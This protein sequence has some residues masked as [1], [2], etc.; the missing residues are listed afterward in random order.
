MYW[1]ASG[2]PPPKKNRLALN[3]V[4]SCSFFLFLFAYQ[5]RVRSC[6]QELPTSILSVESQKGVND[7]QRCSIV[8]QEGHYMCTVYVD[9]ALLVLNRTALDSVNVH[10][11]LSR[12]GLLSFRNFF[13]NKSG[14]ILP[15]SRQVIIQCSN[16]NTREM[17]IPQL[18]YI[19]SLP[20]VR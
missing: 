11:A 14:P 20:I 1:V 15:D 3:T 4:L 9:S 12:L 17:K 13:V 16:S 8:N 2:C 18:L 6:R 5:L 7:I 10:L 19:F